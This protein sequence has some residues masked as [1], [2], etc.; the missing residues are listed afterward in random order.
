MTVSDV[1]RYSPLLMMALMLYSQ[2]A[3]AHYNGDGYLAV[4]LAAES[5]EVTEDSIMRAFREYTGN[6]RLTFLE[7]YLTQEGY[8][9]PMDQTEAFIS[10]SYNGWSKYFTQQRDR[11]WREAQILWIAGSGALDY[12]DGRGGVSRKIIGDTDPTRFTVERRDCQI[13]YVG[14]RPV[15]QHIRFVRSDSNMAHVFVRVN[16]PVD[17]AFGQALFRHLERILPFLEMVVNIRSDPWFFSD[18]LYPVFDPILTPDQPP[19]LAEYTKSPMILCS[20]H[21]CTMFASN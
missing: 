14:F 6:R 18:P 10:R 7:M 15:P 21:S 12:T 13:L 3:R 20:S 1:I 2:T 8:Y 19:S 17:T 4:S 16:G 9:S 11:T 5:S